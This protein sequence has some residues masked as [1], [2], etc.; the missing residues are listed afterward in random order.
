MEPNQGP[1]CWASALAAGMSVI[2]GTHV[3]AD[4][5]R[6]LGKEISPT[7]FFDIGVPPWEQ[8]DVVN[9]STYPVS[10]AYSSWNSRADLL[11]NLQMGTPVV[12]TIT[13]PLDLRSSD[14][15]GF[16][17]AILT[18]G[19]DPVIKQF[20][21]ADPNNP[22]KRLTE[23]DLASLYKRDFDSLW[24]ADNFDLYMARLISGV[25]PGSMVTL[26]KE[27]KVTA[28]PSQPSQP[29]GGSGGGRDVKIPNQ[30]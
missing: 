13:L 22:G 9:L 19:Y 20:I 7:G 5:I 15:G 17:H 3:P 16:A 4:S 8:D 26:E 12:V 23:S 1:T 2:E 21:F 28:P 27:P 11:N 18:I 24:N 10:G 14:L 30:I 25:E 29:G 6:E